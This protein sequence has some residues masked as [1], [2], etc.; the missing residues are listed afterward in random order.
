M[1]ID[2]QI[3]FHINIREY[4]HFIKAFMKKNVAL[5]LCDASVDASYELFDANLRE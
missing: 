3:H 5:L 4:V 2:F 1:G